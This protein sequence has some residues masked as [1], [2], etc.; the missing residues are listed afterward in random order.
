MKKGEYIR[1]LLRS[2]NFQIKDVASLIGISHNC[3]N[4]KLK[5]RIRFNEDDINVLI[6]LLDMSYEDIF[7]KEGI[8]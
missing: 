1:C 3:F 6:D 4:D 7:R 2:N 5:G 8:V